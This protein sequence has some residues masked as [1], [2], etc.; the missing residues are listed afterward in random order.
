[1]I[2]KK[3]VL[4]IA[5]AL[6]AAEV[7]A[8]DLSDADVQSNY[9]RALT[10]RLTYQPEYA[11][12]IL[13]KLV[14]A[15]P[16]APQLRFDLGV[17]QA[18]QGRCAQAARTF[19]RGED[20]AKTPTFTRA[21]EVAM[22]DLCPNLAP[23]DTS[24][25]VSFGYDSNVN[26]G[27][28]S[29]YINI[30]GIPM[31]LNDEA[32]AQGAYGYTLNGSVSYNHKISQTGYVVPSVSLIVKDYEGSEFDRAYVSAGLSYRFRGDQVDWRVG[33][34]L[35]WSF[36]SDGLTEVGQGIAASLA[37]EMSK[38]SG[39]YV[40]A[41]AHD[42]KDKSGYEEDHT[43]FTFGTTYVRS[44]NSRNMVFRAGL[45]L[46]KTDYD[47]S[48]NDLDTLA[49][50]FGLSGSLTSQIGFDVYI[51]HAIHEGSI[52][53]PFFGEVREDDITTVGANFSF[54]KFEGWYGRPYVGVQHAISES[55]FDTKDYDKT[56]ITFGLTRKF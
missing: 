12:A 28:G 26:G 46:A 14:E 43:D 20:L 10:A 17:S 24:A 48:L 53:H 27:S 4:T 22:D 47:Q 54:A 32:M 23:W 11:E 33:P 19:A 39:L 41:S 29:R 49:L 55:S 38:T 31:R 6:V 34:S 7:G 2:G 51:N 44:L 35:K 1:M 8:T 9:E 42:F 45:S 3:F 21:A 15:R 30:G 25:G 37:W 50:E 13:V 56:S 36:D 40:N 18:E 5:T 52:V 16:N